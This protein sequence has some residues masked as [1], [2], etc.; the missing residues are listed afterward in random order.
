MY[1]QFKI[2]KN[3]YS[4]FANKT[5]EEICLA[6]DEEPELFASVPVKSET[7]CFKAVS[8]DPTNIAFVKDPC[9]SLQLSA[10]SRLPETI[11]IIDRPTKQVKIVA[12]SRA[13]H[14]LQY[15]RQKVFTVSEAVRNGDGV[16]VGSNVRHSYKIIFKAFE[17]AKEVGDEDFVFAVIPELINDFVFLK[18]FKLK[19]NDASI[20]K[21][22]SDYALERYVQM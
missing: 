1:P 8:S 13:Y 15:I 7:I 22:L 4:A 16:I 10:V 11:A 21:H 2:V 9:V 12:V 14:T 6:V 17:R 18:E 3:P 20:L 19:Y 5:E